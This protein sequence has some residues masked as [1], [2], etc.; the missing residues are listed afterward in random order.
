MPSREDILN[1]KIL[2]VDD[3]PDNIE[4]MEEIL[5]EEGYTSVSSTMLWRGCLRRSVALPGLRMKNP[6][7]AIW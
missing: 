3:S 5:R 6:S 7:S 4:L 1:A 2:V